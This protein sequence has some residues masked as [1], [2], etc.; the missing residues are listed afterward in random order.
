MRKYFD[1]GA[2]W[3]GYVSDDIIRSACFIYRN[4]AD[5]W[6]IAGVHTPQTERRKGYAR[7]VV[8]SALTHIL[9]RGLVPRYETDVRNTSSIKLAESLKMKQFLRIDHFLLTR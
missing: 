9:D 4:Y 8:T 7:I 3:F 6:E 2:V 1:N 5:I